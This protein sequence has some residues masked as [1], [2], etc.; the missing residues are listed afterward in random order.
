MLMSSVETYQALSYPQEEWESKHQTINCLSQLIPTPPPPHHLRATTPHFTPH[1]SCLGNTLPPSSF[2][3]AL[4]QLSGVEGTD[5]GLPFMEQNNS[6]LLKSVNLTL[7][8]PCIKPSKGSLCPWGACPWGHCH[9]YR[10]PRPFPLGCFWNVPSRIARGHYFTVSAQGASKHPSSF[11]HGPTF[12]LGDGAPVTAPSI[13]VWLTLELY[14]FF[15][16][17]R[18]HLWYME[19]PR[20]LG[21]ELEL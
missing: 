6:F 10:I 21:L 3:F 13:S 20:R 9:A 19:V 4:L 7:S 15:S 5:C 8:L 12:S 11:N 14:I 16:F 2:S 17:L 18:L 1:P